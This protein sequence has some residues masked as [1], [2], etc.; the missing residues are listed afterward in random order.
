MMYDNRFVNDEI[1]KMF[2]K[3]LRA[4]HT[5]LSF[6]QLGTDSVH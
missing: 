2:G 3:T 4:D 6:T 5:A 1:S